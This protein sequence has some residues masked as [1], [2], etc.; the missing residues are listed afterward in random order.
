[1]LVLDE[2]TATLTPGEAEHLF[3]VMNDLRLL[4]VGMVFISHHLDE[5]FTIC[6]RITVLRDGAYIETLATGDTNVEEL[7]RLM[8]GRKIENAFPVKQHPVDTATV[9]L[10]AEIQRETR[11]DRPLPPA[12]GRDPRLRRA[13]GLR[14]H[15]DRLG[16]DR[17]RPLPPQTRQP[18]RPTGGA[19]LPARRR[20]RRASACCR[21]AAKPKA[22]CCRSRWRRT[23]PQPAPPAR[24]DL[25]QRPEG[26][27]RGAAADP[28]RGGENPGR[29]DRRQHPERR[30][31][32]EG[33][34]RP[35]AQQRLQHP[36]LRRADAR[37]RR[38][39]QGRDLP[40]DAAT[41][42]AGHLH[43]HDFLRTAG[44]SSACATACWC[45]AAATSSPS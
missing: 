8:V 10:E 12:Q 31:P 20:W 43:H 44:R 6:D 40:A 34:D 24:Q 13:G 25:R 23:S 38:G 4:G 19:A 21:R 35:L 14:A 29:R 17:R 26:S 32:A 37:H 9:L 16:A 39:R 11:R 27:R 7:V 1:M 36:D 30:Q 18:R 33:G 42:P 45:F 15:R 28:R 22:W 41:D 2:P 5:I 3:S